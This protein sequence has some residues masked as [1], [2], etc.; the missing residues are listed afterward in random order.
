MYLF[1]LYCN[2]FWSTKGGNGHLGGNVT[3]CCNPKVFEDV[4]MSESKQMKDSMGI[5]GVSALSSAQ[6]LLKQQHSRCGLAS[7]TLSRVPL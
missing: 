3:N 2:S 7:V 4:L 6:S 1:I 5:F